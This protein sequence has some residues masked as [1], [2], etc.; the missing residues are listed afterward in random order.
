MQDVRKWLQGCNE[1][2]N[3][4]LQYSSS[5]DKCIE[6]FPIF[7]DMSNIVIE[8]SYQWGDPYH[9][10]GITDKELSLVI[11]FPRKDRDRVDEWLKNSIYTHY[12]LSEINF[13]T[14]LFEILVE[15]LIQ[16]LLSN[17][18]RI[19]RKECEDLAEPYL[20]SK[21]D[22]WGE[23]VDKCLEEDEYYLG[24]RFVSYDGKYPIYCRGIAII[25]VNGISY[26]VPIKDSNLNKIKPEDFDE[27]IRRYY[28]E[29]IRV[30][31]KN[32]GDKMC[33][34]GCL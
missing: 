13:A 18:I 27:P 12:S 20:N 1:A 32:I 22:P 25:E 30:L 26:E 31:K 21:M 14:Y 10:G 8:F 11:E 17:E 7:E 2:Y 3:H 29:I 28:Y 5:L 9:T 6:L 33:C 16:D 19:L 24:V 23:Y 15:D 34:G 4:L